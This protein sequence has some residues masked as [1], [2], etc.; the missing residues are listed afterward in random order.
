VGGCPP[1]PRN[2]VRKARIKS[3]LLTR[4]CALCR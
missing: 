1:S 3:I 4:S 2:R